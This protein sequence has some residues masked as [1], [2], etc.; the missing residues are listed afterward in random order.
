[1]LFGSITVTLLTALD[2]SNDPVLPGSD[3]CIYSSIRHLIS[4]LLSTKAD[5]S[6]NS[7]ATILDNY[8]GTTPVSE[9]RAF[10]IPLSTDVNTENMVVKFY[11][12]Q[13]N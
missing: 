11:I 10:A 6:N 2:I 9:T 7:V 5:N 12:K 3:F 4:A 1:M 13:E 8:Q